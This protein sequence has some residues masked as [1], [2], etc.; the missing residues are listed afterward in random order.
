MKLLLLPSDEK[1]ETLLENL[2]KFDESCSFTFEV[3]QNSGIVC[4]SNQN[5][6]KKALSN[7]PSAYLKMVLYKDGGLVYS[8]Y[9]DLHQDVEVENIIDGFER[10]KQ[11]L[12]L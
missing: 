1:I 9:I 12:H 2:Y 7:F 8:Y 3:S 10:V 4:N 5:I 6:D 11:D